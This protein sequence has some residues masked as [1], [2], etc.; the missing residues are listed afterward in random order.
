MNS[1]RTRRPV[2]LLATAITAVLMG[3][4]AFAQD[5]TV[6]ATPTTTAQ[7]LDAPAQDAT[8]VASPQTPAEPGNAK[9]LDAVK[10]V[11]LRASLQSAQSIKR[12]ATQIIDSVV[13]EDLGKLPDVTASA[14]LA[15]VTG[16]QVTRAAGEAADV[17]VRGLPNLTTTYNGRELFTAENRSVALQD[18]PAG[19]VAGLDVYKSSTAELVEGGIAGLID[20]RSRRPFDFEGRELSGSMNYAYFDQ[21]DKGDLNGNFLFSDRWDTDV[22][23]MG[24]LINAAWNRLRFLDS[25]REN[26]LVMGVAQPNQTDE[27]GFRYPDGIGT[28]YGQGMRTRPSVNS[29]FQ[30]KPNESWEINADFLYQGFRSHDDDSYM[31]VPLYTGDTQFSNVV[32]APGESGPQAQSLTASGGLRPEGYQASTNASTNTYQI[33]LGAVYHEGGVRWSTDLAATNS[34][35]KLKQANIDYAFASAPVVDVN[36]AVPGSDGGGSYSFQNFDLTDPNNFIFRGLYDRNYE[37]SG[38]DFQARTDFEFTPESGVITAYQAGLRYTDRD[39]ERKSGDRYGYVEGAGLS[40]LDLP[41]TLSTTGGGFEG[42]SHA[43]PTRWVAPTRDSIR[44]NVYA[45]RQLTDSLLGP[46]NHDFDDYGLPAFNPLNTF[47]ANEKASTGYAQVKYAFDTAIPI[48][49]AVGMRVVR[50]K[51][52]VDGTSRDDATAT[53]S[54]ISSS[55]RY[56]D[57]LPN[58]SIRFRV[59]DTFQIRAAATKTRTRPN[60]DQLNPSTIVNSPQGACNTDP[61]SVNCFRTASSGNPNLSPLESENYD[62]SFEYYFSPTGSATLAFFRRDVKGFIANVTTDQAD[63]EYGTLRLTQPE[64]GGEGKLQGAE[65]AFT[66]FLDFDALPEWARAFG[67]QANYTYID[68]GAEQGPTV[69]SSIPGEPRIPGV[70]KNSYNLVLLYEKPEFSARLAYNWRSKWVQEYSQVYD[71]A[72]GANGPFFPLVQDDRGT[73]DMSLNYTPIPAVTFAFDVSNILGDPI[74]NSR[75]YNVQGDAYA[76]QIKYLE[77]VYSLGVRFRF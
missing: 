34:K 55:T 3:A 50:T 69:A 75:T 76:R 15:R 51:T 42:D 25:T 24:F 35:F 29:A 11:G 43:P 7:A 59:T 61:D 60:F 22:G 40:Y 30:W 5:A 62:L 58:A 73:L 45:L 71:A 57:Y 41:V 23:E 32:T 31:F 39:A 4:P 44:D 48:D 49:G 1:I 63:A 13:A 74:T 36:Y 12:D 52:Q 67:V 54:P 21:A 8:P 6:Q 37:A 28:F 27:P 33:G 64:N 68:G 14:S 53:Y 72:L 65:F 38:K 17:Q 47:N 19:G 2:T 20:V 9:D 56:T 16:V 77:T 66:S 18:F 46:D 10:V 70:S 26:S